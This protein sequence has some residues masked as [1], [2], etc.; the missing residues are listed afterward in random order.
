MQDLGK[1]AY[2]AYCQTTGG[3][4]AVTGAPLPTWE[5]QAEAIREA[6]RAA[7]DAVRMLVEIGEVP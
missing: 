1:A 4:S 6:W 2:L 5:G 7:A 3:K